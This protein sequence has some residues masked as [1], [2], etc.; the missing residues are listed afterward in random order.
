MATGSRPDDWR[1]IE[2]GS[3]DRGLTE[4][5]ES[6]GGGLRLFRD[7]GKKVRP[8]LRVFYFLYSISIITVMYVTWVWIYLS[9]SFVATIRQM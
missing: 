2:I 8:R 6:S 7:F 5:T 1:F 9:Q 3:V 4:F